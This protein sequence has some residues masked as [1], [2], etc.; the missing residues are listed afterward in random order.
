MPPLMPDPETPMW[1]HLH[2]ETE[3]GEEIMAMTTHAR[4]GTRTEFHG[5]ITYQPGT[6]IW[7]ARTYEGDMFVL[8]TQVRW[9]GDSARV[10]ANVI[11]D[12]CFDA[13]R[14]GFTRPVTERRTVGAAELAAIAATRGL[15]TDD[16]P[17]RVPLVQ[18]LEWASSAMV[19][20]GD[21]VSVRD[22]PEWG[23]LP[24]GAVA[25]VRW[26]AR[27]RGDWQ[28]VGDGSTLVV[29]DAWTQHE[30]RPVATVVA[31]DGS[32]VGWTAGAERTVAPLCVTPPTL[33]GS[34]VWNERPA[35]TPGTFRGHGLTRTEYLLGPTPEGPWTRVRSIFAAEPGWAGHYLIMRVTAMNNGGDVV[36]D[37]APY[38]PLTGPDVPATMSIRRGLFGR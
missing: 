3:P 37:S 33:T 28:W 30:L 17:H 32:V 21:T 14:E 23:P 26:E 15:P 9:S 11:A 38:G 8:R 20:P 2:R 31:P 1:R 18:I 24:D 27:G 29:E 7:R 12:S 13:Y 36:A 22:A 35:E 6:G 19:A 16:P 5:A 34:R 4:A 10:A 25:S